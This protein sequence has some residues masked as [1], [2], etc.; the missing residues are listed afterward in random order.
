MF[1]SRSSRAIAALDEGDTATYALTW[2]DCMA[3]GPKLGRSLVY[4]GEHARR[5]ELE[6]YLRLGAA[7][8]HNAIFFADGG[9]RSGNSAAKKSVHTGPPQTGVA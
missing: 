9:V 2:T 3:K 4:L 7:A 5:N 1:L 8:G 6:L